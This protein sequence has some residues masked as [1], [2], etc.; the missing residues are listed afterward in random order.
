MMDRDTFEQVLVDTLE[1]LPEEFGSKLENVDVVV[2]D[3]PSP[4]H[5]AKARLRAGQ[6]LLGLYE[7]IPQTRRGAH[8]G[9]VLPDKITVFREP[10]VARCITVA[11]VRAEI[12]RIVRHE[13]AHH[14][15][16]SDARLRQLE[17]NHPE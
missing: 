11:E 7:G 5:I 17:E 12:G 8:Y 16:I 1:A 3:R 13:I 10:I 14:F 4:L 2:E 6:T 9:L 15:G